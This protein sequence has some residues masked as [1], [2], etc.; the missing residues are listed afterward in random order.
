MVS[1]TLLYIPTAWS[2]PLSSNS[3][4]LEENILQLV[5]KVQLVEQARSRRSIT[6]LL[7]AE[8]LFLEGILAAQNHKKTSKKLKARRVVRPVN[9]HIHTAISGKHTQA[10]TTP[11]KQ[12]L[13]TT[14]TPHPISQLDPFTMLAAPDLSRPTDIVTRTGKSLLTATVPVTFA[15][16][17]Q[18]AFRTNTDITSHKPIRLS[19]KP[20][21]EA[22]RY[23]EFELYEV[24]Q[25]VNLN[26]QATLEEQEE[27]LELTKPT[28]RKTISV[29]KPRKR[30]LRYG[31]FELYE[32]SPVFNY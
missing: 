1:I 20:Y 28:F 26:H 4:E 10:Y 24:P 30:T 7:A 6:A 25:P 13:T 8:V 9:N 16:T 2:F 27:V 32:P 22:P 14:T 21:R 17:K 29:R 11:V 31:A 18:K 3:P 23:G 15:D 19:S 12:I 5:E